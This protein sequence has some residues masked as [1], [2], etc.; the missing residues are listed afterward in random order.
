MGMTLGILVEKRDAARGLWEP[1]PV[2]GLLAHRQFGRLVIASVV[3][4]CPLYTL[5]AP[6]AMAELLRGGWGG[7]QTCIPLQEA[8]GLPLDASAACRRDVQ[9][10]ASPDRGAGGWFT[11]ARLQSYDWEAGLRDLRDDD[12]WVQEA[13]SPAL[14]QEAAHLAATL[15]LLGEPTDVRVILFFV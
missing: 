15:A 5:G 1:V 8:A 6:S 11:C 14:R 4:E 2:D 10:L 13:F 7:E 9:A 12:T 3:T